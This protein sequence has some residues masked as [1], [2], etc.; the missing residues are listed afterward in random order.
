MPSLCWKDSTAKRSRAQQQGTC[1]KPRTQAAAALA[2]TYDAKG[3]DVSSRGQVAVPQDL[4]RLVCDGA[5]CGCA[6]MAL[7]GPE[8]LAEAKVTDLGTEAALGVRDLL[9]DLPLVLQG[10]DS[11]RRSG[12][13]LHSVLRV[14]GMAAAAGRG[15]AV[16]QPTAAFLCQ[17]IQQPLHLRLA[18]LQLRVL[19][20]IM[21]RAHHGLQ[22]LRR[23]RCC[24]CA[25]AGW[26][27]GQQVTHLH[28]RR[29]RQMLLPRE[30]L[31]H[32]CGLLAGGV[33]G[34]LELL[35][36]HLGDSLICPRGC[37][38]TH[39]PL[40]QHRRPL[41]WHTQHVDPCRP[42]GTDHPA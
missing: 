29:R 20:G 36:A 8:A 9:R 37:V 34:V 2:L 16:E 7:P 4:G 41:P 30:R 23:A 38:V 39:A 42:V 10:G 14:G 1:R 19:R 13:L 3:V 21:A 24:C 12:R 18:V 5:S 25:C 32:L 40:G 11:T 35:T 15:G 28:C 6:A 17:S 31:L 22:A 26:W 27:A 33:E